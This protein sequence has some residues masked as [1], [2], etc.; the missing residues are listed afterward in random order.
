MQN[1][2]QLATK[3]RDSLDIVRISEYLRELLPRFNVV[4]TSCGRVKIIVS[5]LAL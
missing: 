5:E 3:V 1:R 2:Y 4:I